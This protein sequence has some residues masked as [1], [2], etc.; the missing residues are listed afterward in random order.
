[1][2]IADALLI[3]SFRSL[4]YEKRRS[5]VLIIDIML[6]YYVVGPGPGCTFYHA[7]LPSSYHFTLAST[8][9]AVTKFL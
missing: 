7:A 4:R 2:L 3:S 8:G 6:W 1:M 9:T 5:A